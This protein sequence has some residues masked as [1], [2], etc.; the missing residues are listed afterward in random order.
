M[1]RI[2]PVTTAAGWRLT[3]ISR[4]MAAATAVAMTATPTDGRQTYKLERAG[5]KMVSA[6]PPTSQSIP[7]KSDERSASK[8]R[9]RLRLANA[10]RSN[11]VA[12][13]NVID[14]SAYANKLDKKRSAAKLH[15]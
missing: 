2:K 9:K 12:A 1:S 5:K 6:K 13:L 8:V 3:G 7:N 14:R 15:W 10:T 4:Q 11:T